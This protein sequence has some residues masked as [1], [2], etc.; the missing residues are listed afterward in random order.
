[1]GDS[2][3]DSH[4]MSWYQ[5]Y[6]KFENPTAKWCREL[7]EFE[8]RFAGIAPKH[9]PTRKLLSSHSIWK[10]FQHLNHWGNPGNHPHIQWHLCLEIWE[11]IPIRI[12]NYHHRS[13]GEIQA[14]STSTW[15]WMGPKIKYCEHRP[16]FTRKCSKLLEKSIEYSLSIEVPFAESQ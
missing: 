2:H 4:T 5:W 14:H 13:W 11:W 12:K 10:I 7:F 3:R 8:R 6:P 16:D 15:E 9:H 1:M